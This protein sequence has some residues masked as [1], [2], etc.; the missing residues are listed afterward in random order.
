MSGAAGGT[1]GGLEE[2]VKVVKLGI[3]QKV[4]G[5]WNWAFDKNY[6]ACLA[7][8]APLRSSGGGGFKAQARIPPGL[9]KEGTFDRWLGPLSRGS[10]IE[11][12]IKILSK[13][14]DAKM[15]EKSTPGIIQ[16]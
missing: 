4:L 2:L 8:T 1:F 12:N 7:R 5:I 13:N 10:N 11:N 15:L 9:I 6:N 14:V 16:N 3:G